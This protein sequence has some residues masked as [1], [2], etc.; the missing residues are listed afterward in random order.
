MK[1]ERVLTLLVYIG[2]GALF[3]TLFYSNTFDFM[4]APTWGWLL[5]W[6]AVLFA[7]IFVAVG[8]LYTAAGLVLGGVLL[9]FWL[10]GD[11]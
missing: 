1:P 4:A 5:G 11:I 8:T 7:A 2:I 3:H 9:F 10:K 6:P